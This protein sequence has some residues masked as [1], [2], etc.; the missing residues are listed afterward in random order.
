MAIV[1]GL[2]IDLLHHIIYKDSKIKFETTTIIKNQNQIE[3]YQ[4][5]LVN[6]WYQYEFYANLSIVMIFNLI[7]LLIHSIEITYDNYIYLIWA[8][9]LC[10][11]IYY[12]SKYYIF[13]YCIFKYYIIKYTIFKNYIKNYLKILSDP[14][15]SYANPCIVISNGLSII[16]LISLI[17]FKKIDVNIYLFLIAF[18]MFN[19]FLYIKCSLKE[20]IIKVNEELNYRFKRHSSNIQL[21]EPPAKWM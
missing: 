5:F 15:K 1:F 4:F 3:I 10:L 14:S 19:Y 20:K 13:K 9:C 18:I 6:I 12:M 11:F 17:Y 8:I 21:Y 16:F 2:I 7:F